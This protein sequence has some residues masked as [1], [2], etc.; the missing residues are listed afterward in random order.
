MHVENHQVAG[1]SLESPVVMG[2]QKLS[3]AGHPDLTVDR[4]QQDRPVTGDSQ[5]PQRL[6]P[7]LVLLHRA[8]RRTKARMGIQ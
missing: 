7:E 1:D 5:R 2:P 8:F 4:R 3:N 6:L